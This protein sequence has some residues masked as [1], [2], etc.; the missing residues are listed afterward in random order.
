MNS[1]DATMLQVI[2]NLSGQKFE[3]CQKGMQLA[4]NGNK[5]CRLLDYKNGIADLQ[6]ALKIFIRIS[7]INPLIGACLTDLA[8]NY[9]NIGDFKSAKAYAIKGL[10]VLK[11]IQG[12]NGKKGLSEMIIG[13]YECEKG[14]PIK[15]QEHFQKA[16]ALFNALP[17][18]QGYIESLEMNEE[19]YEQL[20]FN[21]INKK[22]WWH[23]LFPQ[24]NQ[25][26]TIIKQI[27]EKVALAVKENNANPI[28]TMS[29]QESF[30]IHLINEFG[31]EG[32]I[33]S[34]VP[35]KISNDEFNAIFKCVDFAKKCIF[36][37]RIIDNRTNIVDK[38]KCIKLY[39]S[40]FTPAQKDI[41]ER[42]IR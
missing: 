9:G 40:F 34:R 6:G 30:S 29:T 10:G 18:R 31:F 3:D 1:D 33:E 35:F 5:K 15:G 24:K 16:R 12:F 11:E 7:G 32:S 38:Q 14:N 8:V 4:L 26:I 2:K 28:K 22:K 19:K 13:I 17:D 41:L 23:Y 42:L 21:A 36:E 39:N 20:I 37:D 27:V 25:Q